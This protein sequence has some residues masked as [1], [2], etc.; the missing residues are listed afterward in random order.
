M[1]CAGTQC[2]PAPPSPAGT[3]AGTRREQRFPALALGKF[4]RESPPWQEVLNSPSLGN[5]LSHRFGKPVQEQHPL[6]PVPSK[7]SSSSIRRGFLGTPKQIRQIQHPGQLEGV[8]FLL[9]TSRREHLAATSRAK[10][11]AGRECGASRPKST[12]WCHHQARA[13]TVA[14]PE[15]VQVH[16]WPQE[17][18]SDPIPTAKGCPN[19]PRLSMKTTKRDLK[20]FPPPQLQLGT[21]GR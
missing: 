18:L 2:P 20:H 21:T 4:L 6:V 16:P 1:P 15:K 14:Q 12:S 17:N 19:F 10:R 11:A 9:P 8:L 13:G 7:A 3:A 5:V